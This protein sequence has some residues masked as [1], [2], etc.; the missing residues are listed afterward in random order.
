[1]SGAYVEPAF[2]SITQVGYDQIR[3][4]AEHRRG[5]CAGGAHVAFAVADRAG[6]KFWACRACPAYADFG[7]GQAWRRP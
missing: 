6:V 3:R 1:V 4:R 7:T 2:V 5:G